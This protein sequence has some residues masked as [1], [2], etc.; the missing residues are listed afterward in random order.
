MILG[1]HRHDDVMQDAIMRKNETT[2]EELLVVVVEKSVWM[3]R[4]Q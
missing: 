4:D 2:D 1:R 3:K